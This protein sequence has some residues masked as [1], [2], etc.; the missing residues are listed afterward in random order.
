MDNV[1]MGVGVFS[2]LLNIVLCVKVIRLSES[3]E[4]I[5]TEVDFDDSCGG[6]LNGKYNTAT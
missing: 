3:L 5:K 2:I 1:M 6:L 4:D